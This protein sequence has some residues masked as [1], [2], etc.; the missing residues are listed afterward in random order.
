M[1]SKKPENPG[2]TEIFTKYQCHYCTDEL[3]GLRDSCATCED[4][5]L[6]PECFASEAEI[7]GHKNS[8]KYYF[9]NNGDFLDI[10]DCQI[11]LTR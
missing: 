11:I 10:S 2:I 3:N 4:F 9:S 1:P 6:C 7:G 5:D 8:H